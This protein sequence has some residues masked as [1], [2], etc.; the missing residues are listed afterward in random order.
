[1]RS[2]LSKF[3]LLLIEIQEF[4]PF[5]SIHEFLTA[6]HIYAGEAE[7]GKTRYVEALHYCAHVRKGQS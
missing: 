2:R 6:V 3:I 5:R 1:M 4:K 7:E